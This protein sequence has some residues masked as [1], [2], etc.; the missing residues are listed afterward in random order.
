VAQPSLFYWRESS[1]SK[2]ESLAAVKAGREAIKG[3][4]KNVVA[5]LAVVKQG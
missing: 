1:L 5:D 3:N 2:E 4:M